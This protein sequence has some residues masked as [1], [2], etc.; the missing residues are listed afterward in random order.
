MSS[1]APAQELPPW[2]ALVCDSVDATG[3]EQSHRLDNLRQVL[4]RHPSVRK[5]LD[6]DALATTPVRC[7]RGLIALAQLYAQL[8]AQADD[9]RS[10]TLF[11]PA[12]VRGGGDAAQAG[13]VQ[14]GSRRRDR[15]LVSLTA[16]GDRGDVKASVSSSSPDVLVVDGLQKLASPPLAKGATDADDAYIR[17]AIPFL[18]TWTELTSALYAFFAAAAPPPS[19]VATSRVAKEEEDRLGK[20]DLDLYVAQ[21]IA[22]DRFVL[23]LLATPTTAEGKDEAGSGVRLAEVSETAPAPRSTGTTAIPQTPAPTISGYVLVYSDHA[24]GLP[25]PLASTSFRGTPW[26]TTPLISEQW[27]D[28]KFTDPIARRCFMLQSPLLTDKESLFQLSLRDLRAVGT[29]GDVKQS[30]VPRVDAHVAFAIPRE[31]LP[32]EEVAQGAAWLRKIA[33]RFH[34]MRW[35]RRRGDD[36]YLS[37]RTVRLVLLHLLAT[38]FATA[39]S[40]VIVHFRAVRKLEEFESSSTV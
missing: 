7:P 37:P 21:A 30:A 33:D 4:A 28:L 1:T 19:A 35:S 18:M 3:R 29:P 9:W 31:W 14:L 32:R 10:S 22:T 40:M 39:P 38:E 26:T 36:D 13:R 11:V 25:P 23:P 27:R 24:Y 20:P 5:E 16:T 15:A 17:V 2:V 12:L 6:V 34:A 8:T